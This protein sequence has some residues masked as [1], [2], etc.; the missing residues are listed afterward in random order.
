M[1]FCAVGPRRCKHVT[2][3]AVTAVTDGGDKRQSAAV[4]SGSVLQVFFREPLETEEGK[5]NQSESV[6]LVPSGGAAVD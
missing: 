4:Q 2:S 6:R 5:T 3:P 1:D